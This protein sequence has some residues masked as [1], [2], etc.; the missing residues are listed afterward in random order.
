MLVTKELRPTGPQSSARR[1]TSGQSADHAAAVPPA[2]P[3]IGRG[4]ELSVLRQA[5]ALVRSGRGELV[6]IAGDA[7]IGKTRLAERFAE[8][9]AAQGC[10]V[11]WGRCWESGEAPPYWPWVQVIRRCVGILDPTALSEHSA[12]DLAEIGRLVPEIARCFTAV[13]SGDSPT[14]RFRLFDA[15]A[16]FFDRLARV[17]P[18]VLVLD[19]IHAADEGSL[20]MLRF[21]SRQLKDVPLL[22]V[23]CHREGETVAPSNGA[24]VSAVVKEGRRLRLHGLSAGESADLIRQLAPGEVSPQLVA[25]VQGVAEG[26]PFF[27]DGIVRVLS[28]EGDLERDDIAVTIPDEAR[29]AV[30]RRLGRLDPAVRF[31]LAVASVYGREFD[32]R[33]VDRVVTTRQSLPVLGLLGQAAAAGVIAEIPG[34]LGRH[35]FSHALIADTLYH[36][37]GRAERAS[38]HRDV[39]AVLERLYAGY[40][41]PHLAEIAHHLIAAG[42][43]ADPRLAVERTHGAA[44]YFFRLF[45][46]EDAARWFSRTLSLL[47]AAGGADRLRCQALLGLAES[48][49]RAN[50]LGKAYPLFVRAATLAE[51]LREPELLARAAIGAGR[52]AAE[53]GVVHESLVALIQRALDQFPTEDSLVRAAL[54]GR[55]AAAL[56]FASDVERRNAASRDAVE[57]ARRLDDPEALTVALLTRHLALWAP[58]HARER[59]ALAVELCQIGDRHGD[60]DGIFDG[61]GW[62][63][64]DLLELGDVAGAAREIVSYQRR[65]GDHRM[66]RDLWYATIMSAALAHARGDLNEAERLSLEALRLGERA[67]AENTA[68]FF[69][70]QT[71]LRLREQHRLGDI[72]SVV[73]DFVQRFPGLPIW[74][75][76]LA[77]LLVDAGRIEEARREVDVL[78]ES[79][80]QVFPRDGNWTAA[81][82]LLGDVCAAVAHREGAR[83]IYLQL[84][85]LPERCAVIGIGAALLGSTEL[86]LG[87]LSVAFGDLA[88]AERHFALACA[89]NRQMG[90]V[91]SLVWSEI[92]YAELLAVTGSDERLRAELIAS[93]RNTATTCALTAALERLRAVDTPP[94][95]FAHYSAAL[96]RE[97]RLWVIRLGGATARL[98]NRKGMTYLHYL[99]QSPGEEI[100]VGELQ[101]ICDADTTLAPLVAACRRVRTLR[102]EAVAA[103]REGDLGRE[104]QL[105]AQRAVLEREIEESWPAV[106]TCE[107]VRVAVTKAIA[108][109]LRQIGEQIPEL[110][111][112]LARSI[113]TGRACS[114]RPEPGAVIDWTL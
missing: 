35:S 79:G 19:D 10:W 9:A 114:Y 11:F 92:A 36:D 104:R 53:T 67:E 41:D 20:Q 89:A 30:R 65:A 111:I 28:A 73:R 66:I 24:L 75:C 72:E 113:R 110:R 109:A 26:N 71:F 14:A 108:S 95:G 63:I 37:L 101:T 17:H 25:R 62:G 39:A 83:W 74:R 21:L 81:M 58:G 82:C 59:R 55:L 112:L 16:Q 97:D 56:Y 34:A 90:H 61:I 103:A 4:S 42:A 57:M 76:G 54:L 100:W 7:G 44:R 107:S 22:L 45:A 27:I 85:D 86:Y 69:G 47:D 18:L 8:E 105:V 1:S 84:V 78:W 50:A 6:A 64:L 93:A 98:P 32:E 88:A 80:F 102:A 91:P 15:S 51:A 3:F 94:R 52:S 40:V 60:V 5:L 46:Y 99:L 106:A 23:V 12:R 49:R 68:Q 77:V 13:G 96:L 38:L 48:H 2:H 87:K 31:V 43:E 33:V 29:V 70:V